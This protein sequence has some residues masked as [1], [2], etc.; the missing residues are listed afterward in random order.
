MFEDAADPLWGP[1][2]GST[3]VDGDVGRAG[4]GLLIEPLPFPLPFKAG[5]GRRGVEW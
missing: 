2:R 5:E 4:D 3:A 1:L